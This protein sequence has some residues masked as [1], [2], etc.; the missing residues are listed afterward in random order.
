MGLVLATLLCA[1]CGAA[2]DSETEPEKMVYFDRETKTAV[3]YEVAEEFP[4]THPKTGRRTLVPACY[5]ETCDKWF[6]APPIEV[7]ER[8]PA[9]T[10]CP[11]GHQTALD[12]PW[13]NVEL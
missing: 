3:V 5:C 11:K 10:Q 7:R 6:P 9:A 2:T 13:P 8:N 12:G 1:G 4:A